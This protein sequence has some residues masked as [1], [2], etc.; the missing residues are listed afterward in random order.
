MKYLKHFVLMALTISL[1][2]AST[3]FARSDKEPGL[4]K[5]EAIFY[6]YGK[7]NF[8]TRRVYPEFN[9]MLNIIDIG[10]A[11]L[12]ERL[13]SAESEEEAVKLIEDDLFKMVTKMFLGE[14]RRPRFAPSEETIAPES[15][16]L[17]WKVNKMFDWTHYLHRQI[18]DI[19]SDD[20]VKDKD[21]AIREAYNYYL[22]EPKRALPPKLKSMA[23]MEEQPFSQYW[24]KKY[25]KFNGAI[26]AYHWLQLAANDALLEPDPKVRREK[27]DL[28]VNEFKQ[29]FTDPSRL[30]KHMPMAH[31]VSP[32]FARRFPDIAATLDNLHTFHDI[33]MDLLTNPSIRGKREE[34]YRQLSLILDPKGNLETMPSQPLPPIP[35]DQHQPLLQTDQMEH[36][37]MMMMSTEE[38]MR[39]LRMS[40]KE[41]KEMTDQMMKMEHGEMKKEGGEQ[42][43]DKKME[44]HSGM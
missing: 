41:R 36:M 37:A 9:D 39:F 8:A 18:Y 25:P 4:E 44:D 5:R 32:T 19:L 27:L 10:H 28:A 14:S 6:L 13:V 7:Y 29:M 12:A 15:T 24:R 17:A 30:P 16:K 2:F 31:E 33:Y 35:F 22:T 34:A 23:L 11:Q 20:R 21:K 43:M 3:A 42:K 40:P 38:Q 1:P 26:W